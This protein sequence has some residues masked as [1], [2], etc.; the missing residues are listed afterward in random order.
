MLFTCA[1]ERGEPRELRLVPDQRERLLGAPMERTDGRDRRDSH[2]ELPQPLGLG[3]AQLVQHLGGLPGARE[4][5]G[6]HGVDVSHEP[7]EPCPGRPRPIDV[8]QRTLGVVGPAGRIGMAGRAVA[9]E[10]DVHRESKAL[11]G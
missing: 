10:D 7:H 4:R 6:E 8:V 5:A 9:Y 1:E 11:N 2:L 3:P